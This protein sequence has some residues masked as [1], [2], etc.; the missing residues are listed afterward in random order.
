[1]TLNCQGT[2]GGLITHRWEISD[3][4]KEEW[5]EISDSDGEK[6]VIRNLDNSE[7]YRCVASNEAGSTISNTAIVTLI[8]R[9]LLFIGIRRVF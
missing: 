4:S 2:G 9:S 7:K 3:I 5:R 1:M 6:L 8:G